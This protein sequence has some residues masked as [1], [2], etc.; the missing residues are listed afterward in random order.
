M[1]YTP[2]RSKE[3]VSRL[4]PTKKLLRHIMSSATCSR[5]MPQSLDKPVDKELPC[6]AM[7]G[8]VIRKLSVL[9]PAIHLAHLATRPSHA[10]P[11][12]ED[13]LNTGRPFFKSFN[14]VAG[15][16]QRQRVRSRAN[17]DLECPKKT[18]LCEPNCAIVSPASRF[19]RNPPR[20]TDD[21]YDE[22]NLSKDEGHD[23]R[24]AT[25]TSTCLSLTHSPLAHTP[26]F[27]YSVS[28]SLFP[29]VFVQSSPGTL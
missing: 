23:H 26:S 2:D 16:Q 4:Q 20:K 5:G 17:N 25:L 6:D 24:L 15:L 27:T 7:A 9:S 11:S 1:Y 12:P 14:Y 10:A 22:N 8:D 19:R 18:K 28:F 21:V 3:A 29:S 13:Q